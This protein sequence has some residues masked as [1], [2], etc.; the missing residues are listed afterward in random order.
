[1]FSLGVITYQML[2]G[3]LPYGAEAA[4]VRN[5]VDLQKL[6]YATARGPEG[7]VPHWVDKAIEK[8]VRPDPEGR[9]EVLSEFTYDLRH[10]NPSF[11]AGSSR[12]HAEPSAAFWKAIS[13]GLAAAVV[14]LLVI[15]L[16]R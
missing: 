8:A 4:R 2:T 5:R 9:Y 7:N 10:P 3:K 6:R 11:G 16:G 13:L 15:L 1:M 12:I 14:V